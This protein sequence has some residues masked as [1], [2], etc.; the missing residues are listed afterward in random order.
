MHPTH[1]SQYADAL[2]KAAALVRG[3]GTLR[4]EL[5]RIAP[6]IVNFDETLESVTQACDDEPEIGKLCP[7]LESRLKGEILICREQAA[8]QFARLLTGYETLTAK[9]DEAQEN[10]QA[11]GQQRTAELFGDLEL[12]AYLRRVYE[13]GWKL[14]MQLRVICETNTYDQNTLRHL[15][16]ECDL[17]VCKII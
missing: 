6:D 16:D 5:T 10:I 2:D 4:R 1:P 8:A 17:T 15:F 11:T 12:G 9:L 3:Y 13:L 14:A 7:G